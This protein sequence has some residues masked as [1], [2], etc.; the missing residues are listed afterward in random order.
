MS[1]TPP[2]P[3][4]PRGGLLVSLR[5]LGR[6]TLEI[7]AVRLELFGTE[8]ELEKLRIGNALLLGAFGLML[9]MAA[10]LLLTAFVLL[11]LDPAY[12]LPSLGL[13]ALA[14]ALAAFWLLRRAR[15]A[16]QNEGDGAFA[17]SR[18]ELRRDRE[19]LGGASSP[20]AP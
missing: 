14:Y 4:S 11:M 2:T 20:P 18:A 16:L 7:V 15:A 1:A 3:A 10:L 13:L 6:T 9:A 19:S 8:L 12:R 5:R 17:L